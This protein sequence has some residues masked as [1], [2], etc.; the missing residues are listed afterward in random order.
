[1]I[2]HDPANP[3]SGYAFMLAEMHDPVPFG[4]LRQINDHVYNQP[5]VRGSSDGL[6]KILK[7]SSAWARESNGSIRSMEK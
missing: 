2:V 5:I 1:V 4:I 7:G 3:N 6:E